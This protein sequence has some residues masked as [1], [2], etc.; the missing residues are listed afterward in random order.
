M[1]P[2]IRNNRDDGEREL[3][4]LRWASSLLDPRP[5]ILQGLLHHQRPRRDELPIDAD[6]IGAVVTSAHGPEAGVWVI[7]GTTDWPTRYIQE[8]VTDDCGRYV[9]PDLPKAN[10]SIWARGYGLVNSPKGQSQPGKNR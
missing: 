5:E 7:A 10:Y 8:V 1:Q 4:S 2:V 9:L 3:V 6:D